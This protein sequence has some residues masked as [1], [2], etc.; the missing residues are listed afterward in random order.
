M[1]RLMSPNLK[2]LTIAPK[3]LSE[4]YALRSD[5][6]RFHIGK[7][8]IGNKWVYRLFDGQTAIGL[9]DD[10]KQAIK[11]ADEHQKKYPSD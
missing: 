7:Y 1:L 10:V 11:A 9:Y 8:W 5:N 2:W 4:P 3:G 6:D